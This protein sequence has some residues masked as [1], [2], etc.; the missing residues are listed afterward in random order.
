MIIYGDIT[1]KNVSEE[2]LPLFEALI[3]GKTIPSI[4]YMRGTMNKDN[5]ELDITIENVKGEIYWVELGYSD[6]ISVDYVH[7]SKDEGFY[8]NWIVSYN[9]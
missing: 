5:R 8:L 3:S 2:N 1:Q 7:Y 6:G 4:T 9:L